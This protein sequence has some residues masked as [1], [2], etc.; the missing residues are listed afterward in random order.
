MSLEKLQFFRLLTSALFILSP[1]SLWRRMIP[2]FDRDL[3]MG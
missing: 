2:L 1:R 3:L